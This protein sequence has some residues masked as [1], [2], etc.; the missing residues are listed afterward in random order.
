MDINIETLTDAGMRQV[1]KMD[2]E[3][4]AALKL[5]LLA[6]GTLVG[7]SMKHPFTRRLA[8]LGC[9]VLAAGLAVPLVSQFLDELSQEPS[10]SAPSP[11]DSTL[12]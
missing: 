12:P 2:F 4:V 10:V 1:K 11:E 7:L 9:S 5:C 8:G 3:D 6:T